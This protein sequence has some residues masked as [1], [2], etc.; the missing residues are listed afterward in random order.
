M[1]HQADDQRTTISSRSYDGRRCHIDR[2]HATAAKFSSTSSSCLNHVK[3]QLDAERHT[4]ATTRVAS[5]WARRS[6]IK[7]QQ[8]AECGLG[9]LLHDSNCKNSKLIVARPRSTRVDLATTPLLK[10]ATTGCSAAR[11]PTLMTKYNATHAP[12]V[13]PALLGLQNVACG[14]FWN[15]PNFDLYQSFLKASCKSSGVAFCAS[16]DPR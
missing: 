4:V 13:P 16:A 10:L 8:A 3:F 11:H 5:I 12:V 15:S 1:L 7:A 6:Q 9:D 14:L 2:P